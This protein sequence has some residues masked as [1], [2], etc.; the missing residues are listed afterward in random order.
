VRAWKN[1]V[2]TEDARREHLI[3]QAKRGHQLSAETNTGE[4][5][6]RDRAVARVLDPA[7][8]RAETR[9]QRFLDAALELMEKSP[10]AEF[11][12]QEVVERSGQSLRSFY[13]YFDGKYELLLALLEDSI[14]TTT[15]EIQTKVEAETGAMER[16][17]RFAFEYY[18]YC[19][20]RIHPN[21]KTVASNTEKH[22][23]FILGS[24]AVQLLTDHPAEASRAF[25]P[26]VQLLEDLLAD[27][28][29]DGAIDPPISDQRLAGVLLQAISFSAFALTIGGSPLGATAEQD[30]GELWDFVLKGL[31]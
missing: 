21:S 27:A 2:F 3:S 1:G 8:E 19:N 5:S 24:F 18:I 9:V 15:V 30:A 31:K 20:P 23:P 14:R 25:V 22:P 28:R 4:T 16:L 12:V 10:G 7:R 13:Q 17:R 11:S 26:L 29:A 6:R